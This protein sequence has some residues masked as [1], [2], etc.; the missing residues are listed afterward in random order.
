MMIVGLLVMGVVVAAASTFKSEKSFMIWAIPLGITGNLVITFSSIM[1][2]R[3]GGPA[4]SKMLSFGQVFFCLGALIAPLLVAVVLKLGLTWRISFV[5]LG[6]AIFVIGVWFAWRR[7]ILST[8]NAAQL[9][10]AG[11]TNSIFRD[12]LLYIFS[13]TIFCYTTFETSSNTWLVAYFQEHLKLSA[14]LSLAA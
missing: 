2:C 9:T 1:L 14:E 8:P 11:N 6:A 3:L 10:A 4:S 13:A 7:G 12:P 5:C